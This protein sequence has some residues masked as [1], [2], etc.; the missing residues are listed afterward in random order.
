MEHTCAHTQVRHFIKQGVPD[1]I[2][3]KI[4]N[5][6]VGSQAIKAISLFDYQV[7]ISTVNISFFFYWHNS[8]DSVTNGAV[9]MLRFLCI[10]KN[11][12]FQV[13]HL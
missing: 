8:N 5:K 9:K 10:K 3:G 12:S 11:L 1:D 2:R 13:E 7:I 4:W 6:M